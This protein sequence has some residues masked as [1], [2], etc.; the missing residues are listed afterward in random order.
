MLSYI[1]RLVDVSLQYLWFHCTVTGYLFAVVM[2]GECRLMRKQFL[3]SRL[4]L[5][6]LVFER[7][8]YAVQFKYSIIVKFGSFYFDEEI[9][10]TDVSF[11]L[12]FA[13]FVIITQYLKFKSFLRSALSS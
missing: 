11:E 13:H 3:V 8:S 6:L 2:E 7:C 4:K 12:V 10:I 5:C 1:F 9:Q